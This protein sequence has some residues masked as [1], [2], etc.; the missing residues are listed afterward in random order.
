MQD[1]DIALT[2]LHA[3]NGHLERK[4][5]KLHTS[6][7]SLRRELLTLQMHILSFRH[8]QLVTWQA[9]ILTR[10]IEVMYERQGRKLPWGAVGDDKRR[11]DVS[12]VYVAAARRIDRR[13]LWAKLGLTT[14]YHQALGKYAEVVDFRSSDPTRTET[15]FAQWLVSEKENSPRMYDFWERLYPICYGRSVDESA[16]VE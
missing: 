16:Q 14:K 2:A 5:E 1:Y 10:L 11:E 13:A 6:T 15:T 12:K 4:M 9:D 7:L 3:S 8:E